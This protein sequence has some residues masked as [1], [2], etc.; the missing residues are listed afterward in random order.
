MALSKIDS[1]SVN[2]LGYGFK[3]RIING[4]MRIDQRNAGATV[5]VT[6]ASSV[7]T[8]GYYLDRFYMR[9]ESAAGSKVSMARSTTAPAGFSNSQLVT[10]LTNYTLGAS[11]HFGV[12]QAIEGY[13]IA[14]LAWG[15]ASAAPVTL[16]FRVRSSLTGTFGGFIANN[17]ADRAYV[18]SYTITAANTWETK[19]ITIA[20]DTSGSWLTNNN[21]GIYV[22]FNVGAGSSVTTAAGSWGTSLYRSVTG[23]TSLVGTSG[24]TF[25]ITGVQ[26][27]K[28]AV[29]TEFDYRPYGVELSLCQRYYYKWLNDSGGGRYIANIQAYS[30]SGV[31]GKLFDLPVPMRAIP[32]CSRSGTISVYNS[33]SNLAGNPSVVTVNQNTKYSLGCSDMYT[34]LSGLTAGH[35]SVTSMADG[36]YFDASAEL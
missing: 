18:F 12:I 7:A 35:C 27:E 31:Y 22:G 17:D 13:N 8:N 3:N 15:T 20:G 36:G 1:S 6:S 25:Y 28:G 29:A 10:S 21:V 34:G 33:G 5:T 26:L 4:D 2:G 32:T 30:S 19:T 24:A 9:S 14:D 16:S 23:Q 11:E